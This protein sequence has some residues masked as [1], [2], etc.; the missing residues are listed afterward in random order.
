MIQLQKLQ[1]LCGTPLPAGKLLLATALALANGNVL[2][3]D[4][5]PRGYSSQIEEVVVTAQKREQ[6]TMSVPITVN[7]FTAQDMVNTGA[8]NIQDIS[9]FMPGVEIGEGGA[10]QVTIAIRGIESPNISSGGDPSVAT[11]YDNA[12]MPRAATS[13]PFTDIARTEVLKGP[14]GTLFGRNATAGVINIVPNRPI[15]ES[16][17]FVKSRVGNY[18]L[19]NV[20]GMIN[21]PL[22][23]DIAVR[24]NVFSHERDGI[25]ENVG[26]G[27]DLREE[28]FIAARTSILYDLSEDT[29]IQLAGDYEDRSESPGYS[30]GVSQYAYSTDPYNSKA[31]NDVYDREENRDMYGVSLQGDHAFN[32]EMSLFGIVSYRDW[33]TWNKQDEDGTEDPT[34]Y[35]DTNNIEKSNI[36]YS[37]VRFHFVNDRFDAIAGGN[38]SVEDVY[39]RT[40]IGLLADSYMQFI[41]PLLLEEAV[42]L[43]F[44]ESFPPGSNAWDIFPGADEAFWLFASELAGSIPNPPVPGIAVV[45]PSYAGQYFT[46]TMDNTGDF[47]N[48]GIFG[49]VTYSLTDTMRLS[50][51]L[52]Y[53]FDNKTY[54]WQTFPEQ[55]GNWPFAPVR[56]AYYP[57]QTGAA[58]ANYYDKFEDSHDWSKTTGRLVYDWQFMDN[59]MTYL[60]YATGYK[61]GGYDGQVFS[62]YVTGPFEPEE[63]TSTEWGIKGD[64]FEDVLRVEGS[65]FNQDL[66]GQQSSTET[67]QC[68][69][70]STQA[71]CNEQD[72]TAQ[73]TI[74]SQDVTT[75]GVEIVVQW[76]ALDSL[77]L[78]GL[79]TVRDAETTPQAYFNGDGE[80]VGGR[81][82]SDSANTDYTLRL[83]WTPEIPIGF[84]LVHMD[85][86]FEEAED[87]NDTDAAIYTTGPW[88]FQDREI[89]SARIAWTNEAENFEVAVWGRNLQDNEIADNPGG[90]VASNLGAYRTSIEDPLTYGVDL[91]YSF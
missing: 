81:K 11:F 38:F 67:K 71:Q 4:A 5:Q 15:Q 30:I 12:Y 77:L 29:S 23:D 1:G 25:I 49:D 91:R 69:A 56:V 54:S 22:T 16:E 14:Q 60:S 39:Q 20:E 88:Y 19:L 31:A 78:T 45:P 2:A 63:M 53:S 61:S 26:I 84:L 55:I 42:N 85:Y 50:A 40:D 62:A 28:G 17:G 10:T 18:G 64:F 32:E 24:A 6:D 44:I 73:P 43:G 35:L 86:V 9:D 51:G 27:D 75:N 79:T 72:Q 89:L 90:F 47:T 33:E 36:W 76:H 59:A 34:R 3:Q 52:R 8:D 58:P 13:I 7:A 41:S 80:P 65:L 68:T 83:D 82:Q 74:I 87:P 21:E 57:E 46:E 70:G 37:E 66:D 48:A